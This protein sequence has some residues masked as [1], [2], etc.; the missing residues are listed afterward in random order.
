M[1]RTVRVKC[2]HEGCNEFALYEADNK[3]DANRIWETYGGG[4]WRC[5]R[6]NRPDEVLSATNTQTL[7]TM[8]VFEFPHGKFWGTDKASNGFIYGPGFK[9]FAT[10][11]PAGTIIEVTA[12]I[13]LPE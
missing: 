12:K 4:K 13:T 8:K 9:G 2:G 7:C 11:F 5:S 6:H 10:D 1:K 3:A